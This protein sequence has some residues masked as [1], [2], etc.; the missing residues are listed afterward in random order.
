ME[1]KLTSKQEAYKNNRIAGMGVCAAYNKAYPEQK[2]S[3]KAVSVAANKL[4]KDPRIMLEMDAAKKEATERALV[5]V[6]DIVKGLLIEAQTNGEGSTQSARVAAWKALT[7]YTGGFD[8]NTQKTDNQHRGLP[9]TITFVRP[10]K[11][12]D[13]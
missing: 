1:R 2:M 3:Q 13:K 4:E 7:D 8:N 12:G 6:E 9:D 10:D 11:N 5:T